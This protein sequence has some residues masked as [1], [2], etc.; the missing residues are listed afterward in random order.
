MNAEENRY[1]GALNNLLISRLQ[2]GCND[3]FVTNGRPNNPGVGT[4]F[5]GFD[6]GRTEVVY[7]L[8]NLRMYYR[9]HRLQNWHPAYGCA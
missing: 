1:F 7:E 6:R 3:N 5:I 4:E 8:R 2:H 9:R